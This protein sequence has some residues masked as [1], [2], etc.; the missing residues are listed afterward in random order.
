MSYRNQDDFLRHFITADETYTYLRSSVSRK[1]GFHKENLHRR[2]L[3]FCKLIDFSTSLTSKREEIIMAISIS[4]SLT[5]FTKIRR[6]KRPH[7]SK[8]HIL[9]YQDDA[10]EHNSVVTLAK[11]CELVL[12]LLFLLSCSSDLVRSDYF[13]FPNLEK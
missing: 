10:G 7:L 1:S 6:N 12:E 11:S 8:K 4:T 2:G 9:F 5:K 13:H 3:R